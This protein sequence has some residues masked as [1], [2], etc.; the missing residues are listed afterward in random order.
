[1]CV[2]LEKCRMMIG[3]EI[4]MYSFFSAGVESGQNMDRRF[5]PEPPLSMTF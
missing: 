3:D 5:W 1:M 2:K 4:A